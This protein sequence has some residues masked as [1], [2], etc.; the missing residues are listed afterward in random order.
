MS[1]MGLGC[2][3]ESCSEGRRQ[4]LERA[5]DEWKKG[6]K[7][8]VFKPYHYTC[9]DGCCDN[10]GTDVYIN[11][12]ELNYDGDNIESVLNDLFEFL[13]INNVSIDYEYDYDE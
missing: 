3:C 7:E 2:D 11:E 10:Y 13:D 1:I 8:I 5:R 9:I 6:K 12:F 4:D